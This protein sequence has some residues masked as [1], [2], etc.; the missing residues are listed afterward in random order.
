MPVLSLE[1]GAAFTADDVLVFP[2]GMTQYIKH[3]SDFPGKR[4]LIPLNWSY[5]YE[6]LPPGE[7]WNDYGAI[8]V[9]TPSKTIQN[10]VKWSMGIEA[11][12]I[13]DFIDTKRYFYNPD[14]KNN[15]ISYMPRKSTFGDQLNTIFHKKGG[16][17]AQYEWVRLLDLSEDEYSHEIRTS[18]L[19]LTV[20]SREGANISVLE[21]MSAGCLVIGFSGVGGADF[22]I[23]HGDRQNC[24]LIEN[25]DLPAIGRA[26]EDVVARL[27]ADPRSFDP[28][29]RNGLA[30]AKPLG[31]FEKEGACLAR[32]FG[33]LV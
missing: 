32:Y 33:S 2:E 6:S 24:I 5:I 18:K 21:A 3:T 10:F 11:V 13:D 23:G 28:I 27:D 26:I 19:Y 1:A 8:N 29:I 12:L 16:R 30:T 4:V 20:T 31:D 25:D 14:Q 9:M 15:K 17:C 22:M 7:D